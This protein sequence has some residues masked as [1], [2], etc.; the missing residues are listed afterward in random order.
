MTQ[1]YLLQEDRFIVILYT[2]VINNYKPLDLYETNMLKLACM[3]HDTEHI[4]DNNTI[5]TYTGIDILM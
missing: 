5:N 2:G 3:I 4:R 1:M